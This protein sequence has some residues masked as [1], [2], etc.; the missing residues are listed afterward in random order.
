MAGGQAGRRAPPPHRLLPLSW[1][2]SAERGGDV[3][4]QPQAL[5]HVC[6]SVCLSIRLSLHPSGFHCFLAV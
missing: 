2:G 1:L 5:L 3:R 4:I 6:P